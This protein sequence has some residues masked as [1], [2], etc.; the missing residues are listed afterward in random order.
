M[1]AAKDIHAVPTDVIQLPDGAEARR[2]GSALE[3]SDS[4]GRLLV[5]YEDGA[6]EISAPN[7]D[8]TLAAP[9]GAVHVR[10]A[11]DV[12][13]ESGRDVTTKAARRVRVES[14]A[15]GT[16][17][18]LELTPQRCHLSAPKLDIEAHRARMVAG[19]VALIARAVETTA[20]NLATHV[21]R[22]ELRADRLVQRARDSFRE[23]L[24]L[25]EESLGRVKSVVKGA[26][27]LST[28]RT[29]M[30]SRKETT[31]DGR[32]ILLG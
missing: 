12:S 5:R 6:A 26:Y 25:S 31:V 23:V 18:I 32:K 17:S 1:S 22:Y 13:I 14:T 20:N 10:S 4:E 9:R 15:V 28:K 24:G 11:L 19:K 29:T 16:G 2:V 7:G 3:L 21:E 8:L 30:R 27:V